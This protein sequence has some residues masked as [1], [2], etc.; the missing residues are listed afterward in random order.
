MTLPP[1]MSSSAVTPP[2]IS[3]SIAKNVRCSASAFT[4]LYSTPSEPTSRYLAYCNAVSAS[5]QL[6]SIS[7]NS[8]AVR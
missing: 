3:F 8:S 1:T 2:N 4:T 6:N 5:M 7:S